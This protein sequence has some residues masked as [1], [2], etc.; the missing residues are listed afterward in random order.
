MRE[1]VRGAARRGRSVS[2]A[3]TAVSPVP[4]MPTMATMAAMA[5]MSAMAR[6]STV[7]TPV[8]CF[9]VGG[10]VAAATVTMASVGA[11]VSAVAALY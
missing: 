3:P 7:M 6:T 8:P 10:V 9:G 1:A 5:S 11:R 4:T 2:A